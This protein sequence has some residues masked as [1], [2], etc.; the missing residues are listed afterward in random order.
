MQLRQRREVG[1]GAQVGQ[2]RDAAVGQE[3]GRGREPPPR[4]E[5]PGAPA[6]R[7][8]VDV[9]GPQQQPVGV[10]VAPVEVTDDAGGRLTRRAL[11][12]VQGRRVVVRADGQRAAVG[13]PRQRGRTAL[14]RRQ[15]ARLATR[16]RHQPDLVG[17]RLAVGQERDFG[18]VRR[19]PGAVVEVPARRE[20]AWAAAAPGH[21]PEP[22]DVRGAGGGAAPVDDERAV[23]REI[24]LV[25]QRLARDDQ[26][27][28]HRPNHSSARVC[29]SIRR[30]GRPVPRYS[31]ADSG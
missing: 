28:I 11:A 13:A 31:C 26:A 16:H 10:V 14:E 19:D 23:G 15:A 17:A 4:G 1:V 20:R 3:A 8:A 25:D 5:A 24:D 7:H 2:E 30:S 9:D 18:S 29:R 6:Q 22:P 27:G 12:H 21:R